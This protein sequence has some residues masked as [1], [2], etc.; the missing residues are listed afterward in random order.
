M[1]KDEAETRALESI[2]QETKQKGKLTVEHQTRLSSIFGS[3]FLKAWEAVVDERVKNYIFKPSDRVVWIVV[4]RTR[5]YLILPAAKFCSCD[6]FYYSVMEGKAFL[7]YHLI[8]QRLAEALGRYDK[9][10]ED[11]ELHD[12]LMAEWKKVTS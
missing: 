3:R 7:C 10:E 11:D 8:A 6:D 2:I 5:D 1:K 9:I 4:G 12:V